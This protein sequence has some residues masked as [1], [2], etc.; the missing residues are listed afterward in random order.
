[1]YVYAI[2]GEGV[3]TTDY[4]VAICSSKKLAEKTVQE[5]NK[6]YDKWIADKNDV[7]KY[8]Y[9]NGTNYSDFVYDNPKPSRYRIEKLKVFKK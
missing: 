8:S 9:F 1:M 4:N 6:N 7:E 2:H 3:W 5:L